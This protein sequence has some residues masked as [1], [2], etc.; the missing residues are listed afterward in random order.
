[1]S[2]TIIKLL[3]WNHI[4]NILLV[5]CRVYQTIIKLLKS[6]DFSHLRYVFPSFDGSKT[7]VGR[8]PW[9]SCCVGNPTDSTDE[10]CWKCGRTRWELWDFW[11]FLGTTKHSNVGMWDWIVLYHVI[12]CNGGFTE[13]HKPVDIHRLLYI[14]YYLGM[15]GIHRPSWWHADDWGWFGQRQR[16]RCWH[17]AMCLWSS[18]PITKLIRLYKDIQLFVY[19]LIIQYIIY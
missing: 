11:W 17:P 18:A 14:L 12:Q 4:H 5:T 10:R 15:I 2:W 8:K 9:R 16:I 1:M 3:K 7:E 13:C 19:N 6:S